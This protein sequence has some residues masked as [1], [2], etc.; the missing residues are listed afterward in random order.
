MTDILL[1][2]I[3]NEVKLSKNI[4]NI[5]EDFSN[6]YFYGNLLYKYKLFPQFNQF[7]NSNEKY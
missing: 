6:G 3:N 5:A 2:W 7:K 4:Q 1:N